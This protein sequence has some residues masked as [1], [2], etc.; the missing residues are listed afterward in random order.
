MK[1]SKVIFEKFNNDWYDPGKN[2][3]VRFLWMLTSRICVNSWWPSSSTKVIMLRMFGARIGKGVVIK[4]Y[5][6]IKYPWRLNVGNNVW[7]GEK[8][9]IDNLGDIIIESNV[10]IS[11]GALLLCGNHDYKKS[12]FDLIVGN[13][14]LKEG[15]WVGAKAII[16]GGSIL[17]THSIISAGS[18]FTGIA[19][20]FTI[21]K[22]NPALPIRKR[23]IEN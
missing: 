8:V 21:Y 5:V 2:F 23:I 18:V 9:W 11:Q 10:C 16:T 20:E 3:L 6:N 14:E 15:A 19:D 7:V 17:N 13:I 1:D 4:P 22:G 12:T